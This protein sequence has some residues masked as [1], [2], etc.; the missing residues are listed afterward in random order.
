MARDGETG[1][2]QA[3]NHEQR[4]QGEQYRTPALGNHKNILAQALKVANEKRGC[5]RGHISTT[6][7]SSGANTSASG[8]IDFKVA[9][10]A[11]AGAS[12][13]CTTAIFFISPPI[14]ST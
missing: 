12:S 5:R 9:A 2:R 10:K 7:R 1:N 8:F 4:E 13:P 11:R 3:P 6:C 14:L